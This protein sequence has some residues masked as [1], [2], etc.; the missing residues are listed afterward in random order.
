MYD[1]AAFKMSILQEDASFNQAISGIKPNNRIDMLFLYLF[2][3]KNKEIYMKQRI[4]VRQQNLNKGFISNIEILLP[5]LKEQKAIVA[6]IEQ[7]EQYVDACKKLIEI[8]QQKITNKINS[9]WNNN[10]E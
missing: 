1:T 6:K 3:L 2:L 7:E 10:N 5:N 4:G 8:N 9:I